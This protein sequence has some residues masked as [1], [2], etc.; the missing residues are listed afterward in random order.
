M[1][2]FMQGLASGLL[3][4]GAAL[5]LL[6]AVGLNRLPDL[7]TRMHA[8]TKASSLGSALIMLAVAL[9][10]SEAYVTTRVLALVAFIFMT[11]PV[12]AHVIARAA[13]FVGVPLWEGTLKDELRD[14]YDQETHALSSEPEK[15]AES[16]AAVRPRDS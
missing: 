1:T 16:E 7:L 15:P 5:M 12:A 14:C 8:T 9:V 2:G 10:F 3:L 13:Y 4:L 11:A 6:A